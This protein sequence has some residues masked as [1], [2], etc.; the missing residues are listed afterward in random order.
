MRAPSIGEAIESGRMKVVKNKKEDVSDDV[1]DMSDEGNIIKHELMEI[2]S[3]LNNDKDKIVKRGIK[4]LCLL[5]GRCSFLSQ[6]EYNSCVKTLVENNYFDVIIRVLSHEM[7][8]GYASKEEENIYL[9]YIEIIFYTLNWVFRSL[10]RNSNMFEENG[11]ESENF[12]KVINTRKDEKVNKFHESKEFLNFGTLLCENLNFLEMIVL[13]NFIHNRI[14][15]LNCIFYF[16]IYHER[17]RKMF[18][19]LSPLLNF[20]KVNE[21]IETMLRMKHTG[22][23]QHDSEE[24]VENV[25]DNDEVNSIDET[26]NIT[27]EGF[28]NVKEEGEIV[29]SKID[30]LSVNSLPCIY[31]FE[32]ELVFLYK[33]L[34]HIN[35]R[36][37]TNKHCKKIIRN[38]DFYSEILIRK[39]S[40]KTKMHKEETI[41]WGKKK[42][43]RNH[44]INRN[45]F[46]TMRVCILMYLLFCYLSSTKGDQLYSCFDN[47]CNEIEKIYNSSEV[48]L[49]YYMLLCLYEILKKCKSH[50]YINV[51]L[52]IIK[53][54]SKFLNNVQGGVSCTVLFF[55]NELL[56]CRRFAAIYKNDKI[57]CNFMSVLNVSRE[58][59]NNYGFQIQGGDNRKRERSAYYL[60]LNFDKGN[61]R[62]RVMSDYNDIISAVK[63]MQRRKY[64]QVAHTFVLVIEKNEICCISMLFKI[65]EL[66]LESCT[67]EAKNIFANPNTMYN[68]NVH[69]SQHFSLL[70]RTDFH[71]KIN[72]KLFSFLTDLNMKY[73]LNHYIIVKTIEN[74]EYFINAY[75]KHLKVYIVEFMEKH[76]LFT[77]L[78]LYTELSK[79]F[80]VCYEQTNGVSQKKGKAVDSQLDKVLKHDDDGIILDGRSFAFMLEGNK[81]VEKVYTN[82]EENGYEICSEGKN[83]KR[84]IM[85]TG[86]GHNEGVIKKGEELKWKKAKFETF[87]RLEENRVHKSENADELGFTNRCDYRCFKKNEHEREIIYRHKY[88]YKKIN[89]EVV[90][91]T[92][93]LS[94]CRELIYYKINEELCKNRNKVIMYLD[95]EIINDKNVLIQNLKKENMYIYNFEKEI[96][97]NEKLEEVI[98]FFIPVYITKFVLKLSTKWV[99]HSACDYFLVCYLYYVFEIFKCVSSFVLSLPLFVTI[100]KG[101]NKHILMKTVQMDLTNAFYSITNSHFRSNISYIGRILLNE[102][103]RNLKI[104]LG[105]DDKGENMEETTK[106]HHSSGSDSENYIFNIEENDNIVM[107][108]FGGKEKEELHNM[109]DL[110]YYLNNV[111]VDKNILCAFYFILLKQFINLFN[112]DDLKKKLLYE[113]YNMKRIIEIE[114][115]VVF[116]NVNDC[117]Y[118]IFLKSFIEKCYFTIESYNLLDFLFQIFIYYK[119]RKIIERN[120]KKG[121]NV[122]EKYYTFLEIFLYKI[123]KKTKYFDAIYFDDLLLFLGFLRSIHD[124]REFVIVLSFF[125]KI[126]ILHKT[127]LTFLEHFYASR[128]GI[129]DEG[130]G[131][132]SLRSSRQG[133]CS[134]NGKNRKR[135]GEYSPFFSLIIEYFFTNNL[136]ILFNEIQILKIISIED[137]IKNSRKADVTTYTVSDITQLYSN[138]VDYIKYVIL[139]NPFVYL[140]VK[141]R[142]GHKKELNELCT[143][144]SKKDFKLNVDGKGP[145]V[146][147][148]PPSVAVTQMCSNIIAPS[149]DNNTVMKG[150]NREHNK[151]IDTNEVCAAYE[152]EVEKHNATFRRF[153]KFQKSVNQF[154]KQIKKSKLEKKKKK[155]KRIRVAHEYHLKIDK[156][157]KRKNK[158]KVDSLTSKNGPFLEEGREGRQYDAFFGDTLCKCKNVLKVYLSDNII[159]GLES[160]NALEKKHQ[161]QEGEVEGVD[162]ETMFYKLANLSS[163][164][165]NYYFIMHI[166]LNQND[167]VRTNTLQLLVQKS[168]EILRAYLTTCTKVN[169]IFFTLRSKYDG[170]N[171]LFRNYTNSV[172]KEE[173]KRSID[174]VVKIKN[175][176]KRVFMRFMHIMKKGLFKRLLDC[177]HNV[178]SGNCGLYYHFIH[179]N[180]CHLNINLRFIKLKRQKHIQLLVDNL[181]I[182]VNDVIKLGKNEDNILKKNIC[183][184]IFFLFKRIEKNE[185]FI[186]KLLKIYDKNAGDKKGDILN[187]AKE[188]ISCEKNFLLEQILHFFTY[189]MV[190]G[191]SQNRFRRIY[192]HSGSTISLLVS[193]IMQNKYLNGK[194]A[195][196]SNELLKVY[197]TLSYWD[198]NLLVNN[199][200]IKKITLYDLSRKEVYTGTYV[201]RD[202][203]DISCLSKN[204]LF[205][206]ISPEKIYLQNCEDTEKET[207]AFVLYNYVVHFDMKTV[208]RENINVSKENYIIMFILFLMKNESIFPFIDKSCIR[209][210]ENTPYENVFDLNRNKF[211]TSVAER[212]I[213]KIIYAYENVKQKSKI[214]FLLLNTKKL[215]NKKFLFVALCILF[216]LGNM[217]H[218]KRRVSLFSKYKKC[219]IRKMC[220][221]VF[222][223]FYGYFYQ[224]DIHARGRF[225]K[226][227]SRIVFFTFRNLFKHFKKV[228]EDEEV[229]S[230]GNVLGGS[231]SKNDLKLRVMEEKIASF[232]S[233]HGDRNSH[234]FDVGRKH[235]A[236]DEKGKHEDGNNVQHKEKVTRFTS[237][238]GHGFD[239]RLLLLIN[240][241]NRHRRK[242]PIE[243]IV[244]R[245]I[246]TVLICMPFFSKEKRK[247]SMYYENVLREYIYMFTEDDTNNLPKNVK[248][249]HI[250]FYVY[251]LLFKYM[252][253]RNLDVVKLIEIFFE[254]EYI[255]KLILSHIDEYK[256]KRK[257]KNNEKTL[258]FMLKLIKI[259]YEEWYCKCKEK[260]KSQDIFLKVLNRNLFYELKK[261]YNCTLGN[262]DVHIRNIFFVD[263]SYYL[264]SVTMRNILDNRLMDEVLKFKEFNLNNDQNYNWLNMNKDMLHKTCLYFGVCEN[265]RNRLGNG[266]TDLLFFMNMRRVDDGD[267]NSAEVVKGE[268]NGPSKKQLCGEGGDVNVERDEAYVETELD[269]KE[270]FLKE[271]I[272]NKNMHCIIRQSDYIKGEAYFLST[273]NKYKDNVYDYLFVLCLIVSK[274]I[275]CFVLMAEK[276]RIFFYHFRILYTTRNFKKIFLNFDLLRMQEINRKIKNYIRKYPDIHFYMDYD[277]NEEEENRAD[278]GRVSYSPYNKE[279]ENQ[280]KSFNKNFIYENGEL[281]NRDFFGKKEKII[282][283]DEEKEHFMH[284]RKNE[285]LSR[286]CKFCI[287]YKQVHRLKEATRVINYFNEEEKEHIKNMIYY[288]KTIRTN[289]FCFCPYENNIYKNCT[290]FVNVPASERENDNKKKRRRGS[291]GS[292][293]G[294]EDSVKIEVQNGVHLPPN[295]RNSNANDQADAHNDESCGVVDSVKEDN[296]VKENVKEIKKIN[297]KCIIGDDNLL[298]GKRMERNHFKKNYKK[299]MNKYLLNDI[300][301]FGKW[302][303]TFSLNALKILIFCLSSNDIIVRIISI[304]GLS[305]FFQIIENCFVLYK[306]KRK[307]N[308]FM[309]DSTFKK[310]EKNEGNNKLLYNNKKKKYLVIPFKELF[311]LYFFMK[312]LKYTVDPN[313]YYI[314]PFVT[315]YSFLLLKEIYSSMHAQKSLQ[316]LVVYK[317][318]S[319][320]FFNLFLSKLFN[321]GDYVTSRVMDFFSISNQCLYSSNY[322]IV[323][324]EEKKEEKSETCEAEL[325]VVNPHNSE[326]RSNYYYDSYGQ[327]TNFKKDDG[328][329]EELHQERNIQTVD[330]SFYATSNI[331]SRMIHDLG[332]SDEEDNHASSDDNG[333]NYNRIGNNHYTRSDHN[334][335]GK[336][337]YNEEGETEQGRKITKEDDHIMEKLKHI[338]ASHEITLR[339]IYNVLNNYMVLETYMSMFFNNYLSNV[340]LKKFLI[341]LILSSNPLPIEYLKCGGYG[342]GGSHSQMYFSGCDLKENGCSDYNGDLVSDQV[343]MNNIRMSHYIIYSFVMK[344][345]TRHNILMWIDSIMH[346]KLFEDEISFHYPTSY[347]LPL[348]NFYDLFGE[349]E[350]YY[351][352]F[353]Y[354]QIVCSQEKWSSF[355]SIFT[356]KDVIPTSICTMEEK[357]REIREKGEERDVN[358]N[359]ENVN[360]KAAANEESGKCGR[361]RG[362]LAEKDAVVGRQLH[363]MKDAPAVKFL[364]KIIKNRHLMGYISSESYDKISEVFFYL[365]LLLNNIVANLLYP[366][367]DYSYIFSNKLLH[368]EKEKIKKFILNNAYYV[369]YYK[370][371]GNN[372]NFEIWN[373]WYNNFHKYISLKMRNIFLININNGKLRQTNLNI[374]SDIIKIIKNLNRSLY[375]IYFNL[376]HKEYFII[377]IY[378]NKKKKYIQNNDSINI[379][380]NYK[381]YFKICKTFIKYI[382]FL[383]NILFNICS[384]LYDILIPNNNFSK[385]SIATKV[386]VSEFFE[387]NDISLIVNEIF[388]FFENVT[389]F[390]NYFNLFNSKSVKKGRKNILHDMKPLLCCEDELDIFKEKKG[391]N[392]RNRKTIE[393]FYMQ[394]HKKLLN[395]TQKNSPKCSNYILYRKIILCVLQNIHTKCFKRSKHFYHVFLNKLITIYHFLEEG[396]RDKLYLYIYEL[397]GIIKGD[398]LE[399]VIKQIV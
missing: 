107:N 263:L 377:F 351:A 63:N 161:V 236:R 376:F 250:L 345:I 49:R 117:I 380:K 156:I 241:L 97:Y 321:I 306:I 213:G 24:N 245:Y 2:C 73:F 199:E 10:F 165:I 379:K 281:K 29:I 211:P 299:L 371:I 196:L 157:C 316:N 230:S 48:L 182:L 166:Y 373:F 172:Y 64:E 372:N 212:C 180:L 209:L 102:N 92:N 341:F 325:E 133:K 226:C 59:M 319:Y 203:N 134:K 252:K 53:L 283:Y 382:Y 335:H 282:S 308:M 158:M 87:E 387:N 130:K 273:K 398:A 349:N 223:Y 40:G 286:T 43:E 218:K 207:A 42:K 312:K 193:I 39:K 26:L 141:D 33:H 58:E 171:N 320:N 69:S 367:I 225:F 378:F 150:I 177:L 305:I 234:S 288:G 249:Y 28:H 261:M 233:I 47:I 275:F 353:I 155:K 293:Q 276:L 216:Y 98:Y 16:L 188:D 383:F 202:D 258:I 20:I 347:L 395:K 350:K 183:F 307:L 38:C 168:N 61:N 22:E 298:Y 221:I 262:I 151:V 13:V 235:R 331:S 254:N 89:S 343:N 179:L 224:N 96:N 32:K 243:Q 34:V 81:K 214:S 178:E 145:S 181:I 54:Q 217:L 294:E 142:I 352:N 278:N 126:V 260:V 346:K 390:C 259:F 116:I 21:N 197:F 330:R 229:Q 101:V 256:K 381:N 334:H 369:I 327:N 46:E 361:G 23:L 238:K 354:N 272:S 332:K 200:L 291:R 206:K 267:I 255:E 247:K 160:R 388:T 27:D 333:R 187:S 246:Y 191:K 386:I 359:S 80:F 143:T 266:E 93:F 251:F 118:N 268:V 115:F 1:V 358:A 111:Q 370:K 393:M 175:L 86:G 310:R 302:I 342:G 108:T 9:N 290:T 95:S 201:R 163:S 94:V 296:T 103:K 36:N 15:I 162:E 51:F 215:E 88:I 392:Y 394:I 324:N 174:F 309:T 113:M 355:M 136:N 65:F 205:K 391:R 35:L 357:K 139:Y 289:I 365:S 301:F 244:D 90:R 50:K 269:K 77:F 140:N 363:Q 123:L 82:A 137:K 169:I 315:A 186:Y 326:Y 385:I 195:V 19:T 300:D 219:V 184:V 41:K 79:I 264:K 189:F 112:D 120:E 144:I 337:G 138:Y 71:T 270:N 314:N 329:C 192:S 106:E 297:E 67:T 122:Y 311:Y 399:S 164:L 154:L 128:R 74:Y 78:N 239:M 72:E 364:E 31:S 131:N 185:C 127:K 100:P 159:L 25:N 323:L 232:S 56:K 11:E 7:K 8:K 37:G 44:E 75:Y 190:N 397:Y 55:L 304:K 114:E 110:Y 280:I 153:S 14:Y 338:Q 362:G 52:F 348:L 322:D 18:I 344:L 125:Y 253:L 328:M 279:D 375:Y 318:F 121:I 135:F 176:Q 210:L 6:E 152:K 198:N 148:C 132:N 167:N 66:Y 384:N 149:K 208:R 271:S 91:N 173:N 285:K 45:D 146:G 68:D 85:S 147:S 70:R 227:Y 204:S 194:T 257:K 99:K 274:V 60:L 3:L 76:N 124:L 292:H 277:N 57:N 170:I 242:F 30:S 220:E 313:S 240:L 248:R 336:R 62:E 109:E 340:P 265:V 105:N 374:F 129:T 366:S 4:K 119:K 360:T 284:L 17:F 237:V 12:D 356:K 396:S 303:R 317:T 222:F 83:K 84:K 368:K 287:K 295:C 231:K 339:T 228:A 104:P 389:I 5:I